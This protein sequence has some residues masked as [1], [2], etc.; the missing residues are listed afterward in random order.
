MK[1]SDSEAID[2]LKSEEV[3]HTKAWIEGALQITHNSLSWSVL[4]EEFEISESLECIHFQVATSRIV[5]LKI[6]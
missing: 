3:Y 4:K 1:V 6:V 2:G 5:G